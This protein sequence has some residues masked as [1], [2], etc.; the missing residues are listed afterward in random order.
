MNKDDI[1]ERIV[2]ILHEHLRDRPRSGSRPTPRL[3]DDLDIDSIDAVDLIVQLRPLRG[4]ALQPD[5]FKS[6]RTVQD[7]VDALHGLVQ[8]ATRPEQRAPRRSVHGT[9]ALATLAY[10]LA[11]YCRPRP[12]GAA[13]GWRSRWCVAR[14][15]ARCA[16][17]DRQRVAGMAAA[18]GARC[19]ARRS[20]GRRCRL[21][22]KLYPVLVNAVLLVVS[23]ISLARRRSS[24]SASRACPTRICRR[25][26]W[27]TR[28]RSRRRG[29]CSSSST[30]RSRWPPRCGAPNHL[31]ALQRAARLPA[32]RARCSAPSGC[33][34]ARARRWAAHG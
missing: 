31:G 13:A 2:S 3:D 27:P 33:S 1:L 8:D 6:V 17:G 15:A 14:P 5:V 22:L 30:A 23:R 18:A 32:D 12:A 7:V 20:A 9:A 16:C 34:P 26:A 11:V 25:P 29:V 4:Q 24:S 10:P 28:A 19:S 21:P